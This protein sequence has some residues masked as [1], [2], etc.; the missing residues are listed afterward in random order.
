MMTTHSTGR[1][2]WAVRLSAVAILAMAASCTPET[3]T[4]GEII[5]YGSPD[6]S[7]CTT[8][9]GEFDER[10]I[11]YEFVDLSADRD[12]VN[13]LS[14]KLARE[15]WFSGAIEMPIVEVDGELLRRPSVDRVLAVR[16]P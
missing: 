3:G 9:R 12:A 13:D 5:V 14:R 4:D 15:S 6:C 8:L 16:D 7:L 10:D 11:E 1:S 2:A